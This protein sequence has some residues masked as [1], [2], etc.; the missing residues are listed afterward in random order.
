VPQEVRGASYGLRQG[1][2]TVGAFVGPLVAMTLMFAFNGDFRNVFW[3]AVLPAFASVGTLALF[4]QEPTPS[5]K[6]DKML[7][8]L[9][10]KELHF[11]RALWI[12]VAT[13]AVFILARFSEAFLLLRAKSLGLSNDYVPLVLVAMNVVYAASASTVHGYYGDLGPLKF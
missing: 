3:I 1:L 9:D 12:I 13:G 8:P 10:W 4:V 2:D 7:R 11:S 5:L 6:E